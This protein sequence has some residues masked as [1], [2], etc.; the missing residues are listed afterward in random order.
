MPKIGY[1]FLTIAAQTIL[2]S[3][4]TGE[5]NVPDGTR[6]VYVNRQEIPMDRKALVR[7]PDGLNIILVQPIKGTEKV[8]LSYNNNPPFA[9]VVPPGTIGFHDKHQ[10]IYINDGDGS[11][12]F[13]ISTFFAF[14]DGK[15]VRSVDLSQI[16]AKKLA[17][18]SPCEVDPEFVSTSARAWYDGGRLLLLHVENFKKGLA[19]SPYQI[20]IMEVDLDKAAVSRIIS[21]SEMKTRFCSK[22]DFAAV[23]HIICKAN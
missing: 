21:S 1:V 7:S 15:V 10:Y 3:C 12:Q 22:H 9:Y 23:E 19:C 6:G 8:S 17:E 5:L 13:S 2:T 16:A 4:N 20:T 11:G 18:I 14:N